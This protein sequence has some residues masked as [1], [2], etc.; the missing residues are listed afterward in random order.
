[1]SSNRRQAEV[2]LRKVQVLP[3][4]A[5]RTLR[6]ARWR[7]VSSP[8]SRVTR[9]AVSMFQQKSRDGGAATVMVTSVYGRRAVPVITS[10]PARRTLWNR[11]GLDVKRGHRWILWM[12][13]RLRQCRCALGPG[14]VDSPWEMC[15]WSRCRDGF[16]FPGSAGRS[17]EAPPSVGFSAAFATG[18]SRLGKSHARTSFSRTRAPRETRPLTAGSGANARDRTADLLITNRIKVRSSVFSCGHEH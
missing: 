15:L 6:S 10:P 5:T 7:L 16:R 12:C 9:L 4:K 13:Q 8:R 17:V 1:M 3:V 18:L 14:R 2:W 11:G